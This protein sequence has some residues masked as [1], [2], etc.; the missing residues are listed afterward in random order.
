MAKV[1]RAEGSRYA[2]SGRRTTTPAGREPTTEE[3]L[4]HEVLSRIDQIASADILVGIPCFNNEE[5]VGNVVIAVEAGIRKHFPHATSLICASDGGSTDGTRGEVLAAEVGDRA[6]ALL[7]PA[8][9]RV[10]EKLCFE[11]RG[12]SGKGSAFRSIVEVARRLGVRACAVVD[13]DL[14]SITPDW[15]ERMLT[16]VVNHGYGFVAPVYSRHKYDGTITNSIAYPLVTALYGCR[17]RQPIGGDFAFSGELAGRYASED[18]WSTDVVR[19]GV[20]IWMST[21]AVADGHRVCQAILG[22]KLHDPKDPGDLAPMFRQVVGSLFML[23]G[24]YRDR[25]EEIDSVV[26]PPTFGFEAT[27]S[28]EP[29]EVSVP[30]LTWKFVDGYVRHHRLWERVLS[31]GSMEGVERAVSEASE[32][33]RGLVLNGRLWTTIVYDFLV[34]Y[35]AGQE[36]PESL[37]DSMIPFYFARTATFFEESRDDSDQEA[38]DRVEAAVD[39]AI[40]LKPY[41]R[42]R[43]GRL[44]VHPERQTEAE[45]GAVTSDRSR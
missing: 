22:A 28:A 41:L 44:P 2:S 8:G 18:P 5:T 17:I 7:V 24:R 35:N 33:N 45:Q 39:A 38:E 31:S 26:T 15:L 43:W 27:Y 11:Y 25:W 10:P 21:V 12:P 6:E 1:P 30:R 13:A 34:A 32:G 36:D 3:V 14:R 4:P 37:L 16:P 23:A 20:D 9:T 29:I 40:E 19:F 42:E